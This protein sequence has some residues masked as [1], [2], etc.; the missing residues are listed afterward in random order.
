M[1]FSFAEGG[2][3]TRKKRNKGREAGSPLIR[4]LSLEESPLLNLTHS[5]EA[6]GE[7]GKKGQ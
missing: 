4:Q 2:E 7:G 5:S 1:R 6:V 3:R